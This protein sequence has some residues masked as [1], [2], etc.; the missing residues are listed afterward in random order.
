MSGHAVRAP[1]PVAA[2]GISVTALPRSV[3]AQGGRWSAYGNIGW[4]QIMTDRMRYGRSGERAAVDRLVTAACAGSSGVLVIRGEDGTGE[5]SLLDYAAETATDMR[6]RRVRG[7]ETEKDLPF[8]A[9]HLLT[10]RDFDRAGKLPARQ[11]AALRSALGL[12]E[13]KG[14]DPFLV[15]LALLSFLCD[16]A[17]DRP[18]LLLIE[19]V[20]W[21]DCASTDAILFAA[22]RLRSQRIAI[23]FTVQ[24]PAFRGGSHPPATRLGGLAVEGAEEIVLARPSCPTGETGG[25]ILERARGDSLALLGW[26][27]EPAARSNPES[28]SGM[29]MMPGQVRET[30]LDRFRRLPATAQEALLVVAADDT[31]NTEIIVGAIRRLGASPRDLEPAEDAGLIHL[32]WRSVTFLHPLIRSTVYHA[33]PLIRRFA[34]HRALAAACGEAADPDRQTLHRSACAVGPDEAIAAQLERIAA[35]ARARG[36]HA[37]AVKG[38]ERAAELSLDAAG[39]L[40]R[41]TE[42]AMTAFKAGQP[43]RARAIVDRSAPLCDDSLSQARL[44]QVEARIECEEGSPRVA[45]RVLLDRALRLDEPASALP[46]LAESAVYAW[47][48]G[49]RTVVSAAARRIEALAPIAENLRPFAAITRGLHALMVDDVTDG[50][51]QLTEAVRG[52]RHALAGPSLLRPHAATI[53]LLIGEDTSSC[54]LAEV[55]LVDSRRRRANGVLPLA[56]QT[57]AQAKMF[58]GAHDNAEVM[59]A[60]ALRMARDIGQ[61][62]R[63]GCLSGISARLAAIAGKDARC[64]E[65]AAE[66]QASQGDLAAVA[67]SV[68]ALGLLD[69]GAG[70]Y[71]EALNRLQEVTGA[72]TRHTLVAWFS[73]PDCVEAAVR[74]GRPE[75]ARE[76]CAR[77]DEFAERT[78][79]SWARAVAARCRAVQC[80]DDEAG[81]H[82]ATAMVLHQRGGR[83]FERARTEL[84]YGEWLR[85]ARRRAEARSHLR[86]AMEIF[87]R[88]GAKPWIDRTVLEL[89]AAGT[90][91]GEGRNDRFDRLTPQETQVVRLASTG[92][93]NRDISM[94]LFISHRTVSY[95]LYKAFRKLGVT[96]RVEL[97]LLDRQ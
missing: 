29:A 34:V 93:T 46:V 39:R 35:S 56:L 44:A 41:L 32:S 47:R 63:I 59:T 31:G 69:L 33:A 85:R 23:I 90:I 1:S 51:S 7:I 80:T 72:Q 86:S 19:D 96:S 38:Y 88:L 43:R 12:A 66:G 79:R 11:S 6:V 78:G 92:A 3:R 42:A 16:L 49:D 57:A 62:R 50:F 67:W 91:T 87:T 15:G 24:E 10:R 83:P 4:S 73:L 65:L 25:R 77:F 30:F 54:D 82:F 9:L 21:F 71:M 22:R 14:T 8:A 13:E 37:S 61:Y 45:A 81:W 64:R 40:N 58:T 55:F 52:A 53:A 84:L 18:L 5:C 76:P 74:A 28:S 26:P 70:R 75:L 27:R 94:Q 48:S 17:E 97:I 2:W 20:Q 89:N 36:A 68:S 95:H 60:E